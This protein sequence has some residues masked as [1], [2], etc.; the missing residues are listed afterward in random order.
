MNRAPG[1]TWQSVANELGISL[2][3]LCEWRKNNAQEIREELQKF[4]DD[5]RGK[6]IQA[7]FSKATEERETLACR[8]YLEFFGTGD[9]GKDPN[10]FNLFHGFY[11]LPKQIAPLLWY[12]PLQPD[13]VVYM[14]TGIGYGKTTV[15]VNKAILMASR[16]RGCTGMI[17][18]PTYKILT[19]PIR[20]YLFERLN[21][22]K[23]P[24][25]FNK[26]ESTVLLWGDTKILLRSFDNPENL[27]GPT[28]AWIWAD[29]LRL[30]DLNGFNIML[31]R[32]RDPKASFRQFFITSTPN[33][34]DFLYDLF[35][36]AESRIESAVVFTANTKDNFYLPASVIEGLYAAYD[37]KIAQQELEA[38]SLNVRAG[39]IYYEF[40]R[41]LHVGDYP[42]DWTLPIWIGQDFNYHP[43]CS[44]ICQPHKRYD[45]Q[46][47][48]WVVDEL[49][50]STSS[51]EELCI[52]LKARGYDPEKI[53]EERLVVYPDASGLSKSASS[54]S[55]SNLKIMELAGF[56]NFKHE[57]ANALRLDRY[58]AVNGMFKNSKGDIRLRIDKRCKWT[59]RDMEREVY[60][61]GTTL[62]DDKDKELGHNADALGY[63]IHNQ[64]NIESPYRYTY[65]TT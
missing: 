30:G 44:V 6:V 26:Q 13:Q 65:R 40:D 8:T 62:R 63:V 52:E 58:N 50:M 41:D 35:E 18:A 60:K 34:F 61:Q 45:G 24:F 51:T 43:M 47:E 4:I 11:P 33:G 3:S 42:I 48:L 32:V 5:G 2:Q 19:T 59:I 54:G 29:E 53:N 9:E 31:G 55:R 23:I 15:G 1:E 56:T 10:T 37:S 17:C 38:K 57:R 36:N 16:N 7:L 22:L 21:L 46:D 39:N 28:L 14:K 12:D 49:H 25:K 20:D 27:R 64:Y